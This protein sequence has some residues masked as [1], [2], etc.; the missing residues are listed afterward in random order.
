MG[1]LKRVAAYTGT[2]NL[3]K[4]MVPAVK[5]L[6]IN[7]NVEKIYLLIEDDE[8]P[9]AMP[10]QV[11]VI[12]VSNQ[13]YFKQDGPNTN[14]RW[15]YM[16]LM[17]VVFA[18]M[19]PDLDRILSLDV[20]TIISKDISEIWDLDLD[21]Y[22]FAA[23]A[24]PDKSSEGNLYTNAGVVL[25]NLDALRDGKCREIIDVLN[26]KEYPFP[27]Q[28]ALNEKCQNHILCI[29]GDYNVTNFTTPT[30]NPKIIHYAAIKKWGNIDLVKEYAKAPWD[31]IFKHRKR[32]KYV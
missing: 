11:E 2:R 22:Y 30:S 6:L 28:D 3:Y 20:D 23:V 26:E 7:S 29:P 17:R 18:D 10:E 21:G 27:D 19:F 9:F 1:K 12:N 16:A 25:Y 8:F 14:S 5:S 4:L 32:M 31:E 13:K 24:E 15:T